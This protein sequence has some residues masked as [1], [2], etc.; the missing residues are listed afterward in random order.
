MRLLKG[1]TIANA[2]DTLDC[3]AKVS[4]GPIQYTKSVAEAGLCDELQSS[5]AHNFNDVHLLATRAFDVGG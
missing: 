4:I 2:H 1:R 5:A 3:V